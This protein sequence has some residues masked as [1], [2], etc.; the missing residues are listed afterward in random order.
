MF[1]IKRKGIAFIIIAFMIMVFGGC[2]GVTKQIV[3]TGTGEKNRF[4]RVVINDEEIKALKWE[5]SSPKE[6]IKIRT[7]M[8][9]N[10]Y[11]GNSFVKQL[12]EVFNGYFKHVEVRSGY[13]GPKIGELVLTPKQMIVSLISGDVIERSAI[14]SVKTTVQ[15]TTPS[16]HRLYTVEKSST[17][18][19][20]LG[21]SLLA[22]G[23]LGIAGVVQEQTYKRKAAKKAADLI[24]IECLDRIVSADSFKTYAASFKMAQTEAAN[25]NIIIKF[26]DDNSIISNNSIDAGEQSAIT[27]TLTNNGKGTA[28][29]V[30]LSAESLY[31]NIQF[32]QNNLRG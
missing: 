8:G 13:T 25:L 10:S 23:T 6:R 1:V 26:Y 5:L 12:K 9:F 4:I 28:F 20:S 11:N 3:R 29:D 22:V 17:Y 15:V 24:A 2:G 27:A 16:D 21:A 18:S 30:N 32:P 31:K 19:P 14:V 7:S